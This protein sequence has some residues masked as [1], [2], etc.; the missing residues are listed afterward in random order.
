MTHDEIVQR[1]ASRLQNW[2]ENEKERLL[3][4]TGQHTSDGQVAQALEVAARMWRE[5]PGP[6]T[7]TK[8]TET[9]TN[10]ITRAATIG[11][12]AFLTTTLK[13]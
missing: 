9:M 10:S 4:D 3:S 8:T 13:P 7:E 1:L 12:A 5:R 2:I 6:K 11:A